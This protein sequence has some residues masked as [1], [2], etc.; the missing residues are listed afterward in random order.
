[1]TFMIV[2]LILYG[3]GLGACHL[4]AMLFSGTDASLVR[5]IGYLPILNVVAAI[6][7]VFFLF[8]IVRDSREGKKKQAE[9]EEQVGSSNG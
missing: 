7:I 9:K 8:Y 1:M 3:L 4:S 5:N 2:F 6:L